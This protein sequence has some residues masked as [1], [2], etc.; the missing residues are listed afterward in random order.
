MLLSVPESDCRML[1][2]NMGARKNRDTFHS[3]RGAPTGATG[4][5][6]RPAGIWCGIGLGV[7]CVSLCVVAAGVRAAPARAGEFLEVVAQVLGPGPEQVV[8]ALVFAR[9]QRTRGLLE[10]GQ[11]A[12]HGGHHAVGRFACRARTASRSAC[13]R[14]ASSTSLRSAT[15]APPGWRDE[16][17]PMAR[18]Q[19]DFARDHTE[20]GAADAARGF[21]RRRLGRGGWLVQVEVDQLAG[22]VVEHQQR[23]GFGMPAQLFAHGVLAARGAGAV[24]PGRRQFDLRRRAA[25]DHVQSRDRR[26]RPAVRRPGPAADGRRGARRSGL[27]DRPF[28]EG[29][30]PP[31]KLGRVTAQRA[32]PLRRNVSHRIAVGLEDVVVDHGLP[33]Q[34]LVAGQVLQAEQRGQETVHRARMLDPRRSRGPTSS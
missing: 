1:L 5:P 31:L 32:L 19:R 30:D 27:V 3:G 29:L 6:C 21:V 13:T 8:E 15:E 12:G 9:E 33:E 7:H 17:V 20:L 16:P 34:L 14:R 28:Q 2:T 26:R 4:A 18:Q 11:V 24:L 22:L 10:A 23:R 25:A